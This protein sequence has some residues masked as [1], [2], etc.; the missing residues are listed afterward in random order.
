MFALHTQNINKARSFCKYHIKKNFLSKYVLTPFFS[1]ILLSNSFITHW[2]FQ[3]FLYIIAI[4]DIDISN[5]NCNNKKNNFV[6]L[7]GDQ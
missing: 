5:N 1:I 2:Y 3:H 4:S 6:S 7:Y